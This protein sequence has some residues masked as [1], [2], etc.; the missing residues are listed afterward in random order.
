VKV[1]TLTTATWFSHSENAASL[2]PKDDGALALHLLLFC[3]AFSGILRGIAMYQ[4][5]AIPHC[6]AW[7]DIGKDLIWTLDEFVS[8]L[9]PP[10]SSPV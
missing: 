3:S 1:E 8:L 4:Q 2:K 10:K 6:V 7:Q 5:L 9:E